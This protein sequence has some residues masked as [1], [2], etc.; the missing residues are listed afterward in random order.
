MV[1]TRP[2]LAFAATVIAGMLSLTDAFG[3]DLTLAAK[4]AE[5]KRAIR[6]APRQGAD[7]GAAAKTRNQG[8]DGKRVEKKR[9]HSHKISTYSLL[10]TP[11]LK[12]GTGI[13]GKSRL[14][15]S[16]S[17][18][19]LGTGVDYT[20]PASAAPVRPKNTSDMTPGSR[21]KLDADNGTGTSLDCRDKPSNTSP[22]R[23]EMTAC[24]V[25]KLD[26]SWKTQ[27]YVSRRSADGN[28][29]W[30]GGLAVGYDY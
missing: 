22:A 29:G 16:H 27:T 15:G 9:R 6:T 3:A 26:K 7:K 30:G 17:D 12:H 11:S 2:A 24:F 5:I 21:Y 28:S 18:M 14:G 13:S 19:G 4:D 20:T 25:H 23:R 8:N 1:I 10:N